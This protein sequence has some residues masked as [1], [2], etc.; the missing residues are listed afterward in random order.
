M[1]SNDKDYFVALIRKNIN[2]LIFSILNNEDIIQKENNILL[3][4]V[5]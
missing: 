3:L 5:L 2:I 1:K 4:K